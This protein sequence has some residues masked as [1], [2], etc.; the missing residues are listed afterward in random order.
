M[1]YTTKRTKDFLLVHLI[2]R[3]SAEDHRTFAEIVSLINHAEDRHVILDVAELEDIDPSGFGMLIVA[4]ESAQRNNG[5]FRIRHASE[6]FKKM[7][8]RV[9]ASRLMRID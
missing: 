2:G 3:L 6:H 5:E 8:R 1:R 4:N 9:H 7:A